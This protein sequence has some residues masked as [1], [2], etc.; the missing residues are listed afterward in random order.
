MPNADLKVL[1]GTGHLVHYEAAE[2][3]AELIAE[4]LSASSVKQ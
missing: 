2:D 4:H 1:Q 3:A